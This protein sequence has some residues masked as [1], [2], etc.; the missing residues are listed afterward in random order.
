MFNRIMAFVQNPDESPLE[1]ARRHV[2]FLI[3]TIE[4]HPQNA[5]QERILVE[6]QRLAETLR[7]INE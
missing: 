2:G 6:L 7:N 4:N 3:Q 1:N 5:T